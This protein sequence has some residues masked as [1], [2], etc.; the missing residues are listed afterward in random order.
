MVQTLLTICRYE[1]KV[2]PGA[3]FHLKSD[4]FESDQ[5]IQT[6]IIDQDNIY[7]KML[8]IY[9]Q[10][11]VMYLE[12]DSDASIYRTNYPLF[13]RKGSDYYEVDWLIG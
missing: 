1:T 7:T 13:Q 10:N 5:E 12:Q 8:S 6:I 4:W 11:F 9:P 2:A 3:Y